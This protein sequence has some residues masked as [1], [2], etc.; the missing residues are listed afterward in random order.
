MKDPRHCRSGSSRLTIVGVHRGDSTREPPSTRSGETADGR[1]WELASHEVAMPV[2]RRVHSE[3]STSDVL[4][5]ARKHLGEMFRRLAEQEVSRVEEAHLMPAHVH[6]ML[7]IPPKFAVSQVV[8]FIKGKSAIH[9]AR[10]NGSVGTEP[11][12]EFR[13]RPVLQ[14]T[15]ALRCSRAAIRQSALSPARARRTSACNDSALS[16]QVRPLMCMPQRG[17]S[18]RAPGAGVGSCRTESSRRSPAWHVADSRSAAGAR[19]AP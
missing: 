14:R 17:S 3:V 11:D 9:L 13:R 19:T 5:R 7:R 18:C 15:V 12:C 8:S 16:A 6:M 4:P 10:F 1:V 2:P